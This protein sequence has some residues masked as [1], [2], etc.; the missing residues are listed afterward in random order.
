MAIWKSENSLLTQLGVEILNKVKA[1]VGSITVTRVVAGSGRVAES[2]LFRQTALSGNTKLMVISNKNIKESGSEISTYISNEDLTES[3]D[4]NQIGIFV[5]HE[6]YEGEILYHI[7][8]C[9]EEGFDVIPPLDETPVNFGYNLFLEHSNSSSINITVDPQGAVTVRDFEVYQVSVENRISNLTYSDVGATPYGLTDAYYNVY[10]EGDLDPLLDDILR[11]MKNN[12]VKFINIHFESVHSKLEGGTYTFRI[13]KTWDDYCTIKASRYCNEDMG[14]VSE[15]VR[16][17]YG[18]VW[19]QWARTYNTFHRPTFTDV[20]AAPSGII[21]G[22]GI[23]NIMSAEDLDTRLTA[24]YE[25]MPN[26]T[27][28][29]IRATIQVAHPVLG[30]GDRFFEIFRANVNYGTVRAVGYT[31]NANGSFLEHRRS[32]YN[33]VWTDW[34]KVSS[35]NVVPATIE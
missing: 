9:E 32:Y 22:T 35:T 27:I 14:V 4:L 30:G 29:F 23:T 31:N 17:K 6:D 19:T 15:W 16:S 7:S 5:T 1:G 18:G 3:F 25:S 28:K 10:T 33:K 34:V 13:D 24:L 21:D 2:Q 12:S 11:S 8:Q 20:G 26:G